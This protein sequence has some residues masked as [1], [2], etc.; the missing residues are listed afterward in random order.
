MPTVWCLTNPVLLQFSER[1]LP[2]IHQGEISQLHSSFSHH[3]LEPYACNGI[4]TTNVVFETLQPIHTLL[5]LGRTGWSRQH[6]VTTAAAAALGQYAVVSVLDA[7]RSACSL[8]SSWEDSSCDFK[9]EIW[10]KNSTVW[11]HPWQTRVYVIPCA[12]CQSTTSI[13]CPCFMATLRQLRFND[14]LMRI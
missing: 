3:S 6:A 11:L 12:N 14:T 1:L 5:C 10:V 8:S 9:R 4:F 13:S 7:A 2:Y